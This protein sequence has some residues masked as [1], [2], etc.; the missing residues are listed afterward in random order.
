MAFIILVFD[1][2]VN[3]LVHEIYEII[4]LTPGI[5]DGA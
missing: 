2:I 3:L 1:K 4:G 5:Q